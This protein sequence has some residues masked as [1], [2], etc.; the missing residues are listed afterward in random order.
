MYVYVY[1]YYFLFIYMC[2]DTYMYTHMCIYT[3]LYMYTLFF[4]F[5]SSLSL[6]IYVGSLK[7]ME[8]VLWVSKPEPTNE[9]L[10]AYLVYTIT[11]RDIHK[12]VHK[13]N[14][15]IYIYIE[16]PIHVSIWYVI[17]THDMQYS[18]Q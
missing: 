11:A 10:W 5:F 12:Y 15:Y 3:Y 17:T 1:R 18:I 13:T 6:C 4:F 9:G 16:Y 14:R 7:I 2:V 8:R